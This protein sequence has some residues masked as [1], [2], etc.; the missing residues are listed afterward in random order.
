MAKQNNNVIIDMGTLSNTCFVVMPFDSLFQTEY[1]RVIRP[2][3]E[4]VGLECVRGDEIYSKPNIISDIWSSI[5]SARIII[6]ELTGKNANVFYEIGLAHAIGKP[7]ILLTRNENDVPFDLRSLRYRYYDPDD[8]FWGE[9]LKTNLVK[10]LT[11]TI[12]EVALGTHLEGIQSNISQSREIPSIPIKQKSAGTYIAGLWNGAW[13]PISV[14]NVNM[15]ESPHQYQILVSQND[16]QLSATA[17]I[18]FERESDISVLQE[19]LTGS[20]EDNVISLIGFSYTY[21]RKGKAQ[22]WYLDTFKLSVDKSGRILKGTAEANDDNGQIVAQGSI[23]LTK[24][25]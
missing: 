25:K 2:A 22:T 9:N 12:E 23:T 14:S 19:E 18:T 24:Q 16:T 6:A 21:V 11:S 13:I 10:M 20:I 15:T 5:R 3:V 17:T 4:S 1:E 7:V 8:P